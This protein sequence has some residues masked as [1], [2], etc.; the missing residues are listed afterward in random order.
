MR[1]RI[2]AACLLLATLGGCARDGAPTA[3]VSP[4]EPRASIQEVMQSI[5]DPSADALWEAVSTD[6]GPNGTEEHQPRT[7]AEWLAVRRYAI[8]LAEGANLL[9][10]PRAVAHGAATL[11][12]AHVEGINDAA[13]V[14]AAIDADPAAFTAHAQALHA[15]AREAVNAIDA[16]DARRLLDAGE[17]VDAACEACHTRYWYPHDVKPVWPAKL[18]K[19]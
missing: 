9:S 17:R 13:Q 16:R 15:A 19:P 8:A 10:Q 12:D 18:G 6:V 1:N 2:L 5:V 3:A 7:D 11:E 14:R 4:F